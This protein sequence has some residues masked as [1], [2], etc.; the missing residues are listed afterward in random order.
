[1]RHADL[2]YEHIRENEKDKARVSAIDARAREAG[3]QKTQ[4]YIHYLQGKDDTRSF[5]GDK[6]R[7][8][9]VNEAAR[10]GG[11]NN[12][13]EPNRSTCIPIR[14]AKDWFETQKE[15]EKERLS[16]SFIRERGPLSD[17]DRR[18]DSANLRSFGA[19]H[20][21]N[22]R[23]G[24]VADSVRDIKSSRDSASLMAQ[25]R[26]REAERVRV[27]DDEGRQE[28]YKHPPPSMAE[29]LHAKAA[30]L[31]SRTNEASKEKAKAQPSKER[32]REPDR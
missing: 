30:S 5:E 18:V 12:V 11:I 3:Y 15:N 21:D 32:E 19:K 9:W 20:Y 31:G 29:R 23:K 28:V 17:Q 6:G 1:M 2:A 26:A 24:Q 27:R 8:L 4:D 25:E 16:L 22:E 7:I 14:N 10:V 13:L